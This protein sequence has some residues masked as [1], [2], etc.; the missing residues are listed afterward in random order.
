MQT[1]KIHMPLRSGKGLPPFFSVGG[2][3]SPEISAG[4]RRWLEPLEGWLSLA[5]VLA[6]RVLEER[7]LARAATCQNVRRGGSW[8]KVY[9]AMVKSQIVPP[10]NIPTPTKIGSKMGGEFTYPKMGSHRF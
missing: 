5:R 3:G 9:V 7:V 2:R 6:E 4:E 8:G 10:V 1:P